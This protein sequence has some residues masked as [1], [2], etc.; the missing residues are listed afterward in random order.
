MPQNSCPRALRGRSS[1]AGRIDSNDPMTQFLT[2]Y[3][4]RIVDGEEGR[5]GRRGGHYSY[6]RVYSPAWAVCPH[7][8]CNRGIRHVQR[9]CRVA[10]GP[11]P[12]PRRSQSAQWREVERTEDPE[13]KAR[14]ARNALKHGLRAKH[15]VVLGDEDLAEFDALEAALMAELSPEGALQAVLARRIVAA[16]WR[17]E[18]A[19]R[20]EAEL[21]AQNICATASFGLALIRDCNGPRAFDTLYAIA[22]HARRAVARAAHAQSASGRGGGPGGG[23]RRPRS[24]NA[25]QTQSSQDSWRIRTCAGAGPRG[26][27]RV[28]AGPPRGPRQSAPSCSEAA[29]LRRPW[30]I[31]ARAATDRTQAPRESWQIGTHAARDRQSRHSTPGDLAPLYSSTRSSRWIS[32][33]RPR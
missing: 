20:I 15:S 13:G 26:G 28:S 7:P 18:R 27:L 2:R 12:C 19:E 4:E 24:G 5:R 25:D 3:G 21:F 1:G 32:S 29:A 9:R 30:R 17:L 22:A 6:N 10:R 11:D 16:T 14:S 33:S 23:A 8:P 31:S